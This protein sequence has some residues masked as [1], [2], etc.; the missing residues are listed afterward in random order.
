MEV[1]SLYFI[2][3]K[4][5]KQKQWTIPTNNISIEAAH[6][7]MND[8]IM[9][10]NQVEYATLLTKDGIYI[11]FDKKNMFMINH[12]NTFLYEINKQVAEH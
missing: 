8:F 10:H 12:F 11:V 9:C 1:V 6:I 4:L 3:K 2:Y 7:Q 5:G